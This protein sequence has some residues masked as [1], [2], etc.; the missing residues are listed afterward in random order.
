MNSSPLTNPK[1]SIITTFYNSV[2]LGNFVHKAMESL[3]SQTYTNLEL[4]C[5][6]DGS[7]DDT[8]AQLKTYAAKDPRIVI[9]DKPNEGTA[10]YAKAAGQDA[11]TG[12][13]IMLFDH[14]DLLSPV[15]VAEAVDTFQ[16]NPEL[17]M[18]GMIVKTVYPD[19]KIKN[20]HSLHFSLQNEADY[21]PLQISGEDALRLTIGR[22]DFHFR[23]LYRR[24][25]FKKVSF[26][27]T[28]KLL[29]A[30]EIVERLILQNVSAIGSCSGIYSHFV[31]SDSSAK[32]FNIKKTDLVAT[33]MYM[34]RFARKNGIYKER[35]AVFELV[36]Y[37][38]LIDAMKAFRHFRKNLPPE[39]R[40]RQELRL[41]KAF[42]EIERAILF[43]NFSGF[44]KRYH[45]VLLSNFNLFSLYYSFKK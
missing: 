12:E 11:A 21:K 43:K 32:A 24:D 1:V 42:S 33:D 16:N 8:L 44:V 38:N 45:Q 25:I 9:I 19:G 36:A 14:D 7:K 15:A 30:D 41:Q 13:L 4:I 35:E 2:S 23:G 40:E 18:V 3:L 20:I 39:E 6:N 22:Y 10:Q 29:N 37:K 34:R 28:E 5:V 26:R 31:H 17:D 27:F